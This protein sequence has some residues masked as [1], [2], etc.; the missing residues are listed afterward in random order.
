MSATRLLKRALPLLLLAGAAAWVFHL[1]QTPGGAP[2]ESSPLRTGP[3]WKAA[4]SGIG[5]TASAPPT[6]PANRPGSASAPLRTVSPAETR[7]PPSA[8]LDRAASFEATPSRRPA[9]RHSAEDGPAAS[10]HPATDSPL[11]LS[12]RAPSEPARLPVAVAVARIGVIPGSP[13][14]EAIYQAQLAFGEEMAA[15]PPADLASPEYARQWRRATESNDDFLRRT[16]GWDR[17]NRLS[18]L[19]AQQTTPSD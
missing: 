7:R 9:H 5:N 15:A 3:Q 17:F 13:E 8:R 18:A 19:A 11:S 14:D 4:R 10:I 2:A 6:T 1:W 12:T 16:L